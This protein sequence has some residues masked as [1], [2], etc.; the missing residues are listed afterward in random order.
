MTTFI[1]FAEAANRYNSN[2]ANYSN[3]IEVNYDDMD[4]ADFMDYCYT[5]SS[6]R[7]SDYATAN[8]YLNW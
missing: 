4:S 3:H 7:Y 6:C 1:E 5:Y 8:Q 2:E